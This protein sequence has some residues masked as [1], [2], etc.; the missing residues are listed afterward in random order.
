MSG[1]KTTC[2][3]AWRSP[4]CKLALLL[5][6]YVWRRHYARVNRKR[7]AT[8]ERLFWDNSDGVSRYSVKKG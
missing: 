8:L 2:S 5:K 4:S 7:S 1:M 6:Y 3:D